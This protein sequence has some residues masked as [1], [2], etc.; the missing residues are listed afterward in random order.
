MRY[1]LVLI[2]FALNLHAADEIPAQK[3]LTA[4]PLVLDIYV[5]KMA[6]K[7]AR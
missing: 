5:S 6:N 4:G 2:L 1:S 3:R 7:P